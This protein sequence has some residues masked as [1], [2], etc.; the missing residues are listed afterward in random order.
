MAVGARC[1]SLAERMTTLGIDLSSQPKDTAG[2]LI[3]WQ[4]G[5]IVVRPPVLSCD[6]EVLDGLI[7]R[8]HA[9]GIDAPFG[10]PEAFVRAVGQWT[11]TVWD[12][13][14]L[15][16]SLRLRITDIAVHEATRLTPLSVSTDRIG[17]P[18]MRAMALLARHG[19][20]DRSGGDGRFFEVYPAGSLKKWGL[21]CRGH[22]GRDKGA[23]A[24][25]RG[26]LR[27]LRAAGRRW[28]WTTPPMRPRIMR[29][30][31]WWPR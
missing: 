18:A 15:Q 31:R 14:A 8:A 26:L 5:R 21:V 17:L 22:K 4:P 19:V 7:G 2:C 20:R 1:L 23:V 10:W 6:D 9:V 13:A 27:E 30:T 24:L 25:R 28:T 3:D 16:K 12:D 29:S 11:A